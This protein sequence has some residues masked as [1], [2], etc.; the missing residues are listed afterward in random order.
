MLQY[1]IPPAFK[2]KLEVINAHDQRSDDEIFES[3]RCHVPVVGE[4]NVWAYWDGGIDQLPSWC[5]RNVIDWV[6]IC[7]PD[8]TVRVLDNV[9]GSPNHALA[10]APKE[11]L[12]RCFIEGTMTGKHV[13]QHSSDMITGALLYT[14][15]GVKMDVGCILFRDLDRG[16]WSVLEDPEL[17]YEIAAPI[18]FAQY[19]ANH[20]LASR[21]GNPFVKRWHDLFVHLW[22]DRET[23]EGINTHPLL[24]HVKESFSLSESKSKGFKWDFKVSFEE[25]LDYVAQNACWARV[26]MVEGGDDDSFNA[27][28]YWMS[29]VLAID[30]LQEHWAAKTLIG[31]ENFGEHLYELLALGLDTDPESECHKEASKLVWTLLSETSM[32]K[33]SRGSGLVNSLQPGSVWDDRPGADCQPGTFGGLLRYGAINFTQ[34]RQKIAVR[35]PEKAKT[36]LRKGLL[37]S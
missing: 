15:G 14:Y 22:E 1:A 26:C 11:M 17:P 12:P 29:H 2:D 6:R 19:L 5:R 30:V 18:Q 3:L 35:T 37:E 13:G 21:K 10:F 33:I 7:G 28:E 8:W 4:K 36:I 24:S 23:S 25:L 27:S 20:F 32:Q 31:G 9:P 34:K 16:L